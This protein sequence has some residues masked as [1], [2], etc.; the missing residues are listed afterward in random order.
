M[1]AN[2]KTNNNEF[3]FDQLHGL[4]YLL[5]LVW[6][7]YNGMLLNGDRP[8]SSIKFLYLEWGNGF[9]L[10]RRKRR[11]RAPDTV[12]ETPWQDIA[13]NTICNYSV[14]WLPQDAYNSFVKNPYNEHIIVSDDNAETVERQYYLI[15]L[16][17]CSL[18]IISWQYWFCYWKN[19]E[20][21][22]SSV[23]RVTGMCDPP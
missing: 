23:N 17:R 10:Q 11:R 1:S 9:I 13:N 21:F 16:W 18:Y 22:F 5:Q 19:S 12:I 2:W 7:I 4:E 8:R 14:L 15:Y 20:I 3:E 6:S